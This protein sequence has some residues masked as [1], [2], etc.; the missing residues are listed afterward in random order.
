MLQ[1]LIIFESTNST[2]IEQQ[3]HQ[4][5]KHRAPFKIT[6]NVDPSTSLSPDSLQVYRRVLTTS[7]YLSEIE[8]V[9][10]HESV[11]Q[12]CLGSL[13][14]RGHTG[15][16]KPFPRLT[17]SG[18]DTECLVSSGTFD[19]FMNQT[20]LQCEWLLAA[21]SGIK[22]EQLKLVAHY[23]PEWLYESIKTF[24]RFE[25]LTDAL[26]INESDVAI[27][28]HAYAGCAG[29][30]FNIRCD[31]QN[32]SDKNESNN[33]QSL[34][35]SRVS[36]DSRVH[37]YGLIQ[38]VT[39]NRHLFRK[40]R[41]QN[42]VSPIRP[43]HVN[44]QGSKNNQ[45]NGTGSNSFHADN[46]LSN[47]GFCYFSRFNTPQPQ[48]DTAVVGANHHKADKNAY[49]DGG[50]S[51]DKQSC[52]TPAGSELVFNKNMELMS[53]IN[54]VF[55]ANKHE[56]KSEEQNNTEHDVGYGRSGLSK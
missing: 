43:D 21:L 20:K 18:F 10:R 29:S 35:S 9:L 14:N 8:I 54:H 45:S 7:P 41:I 49:S 53:V 6:F 22:L 31:S 25:G 33:T 19:G 36:P 37:S 3:T 56:R 51:L 26:I 24:S 5:N 44:N 47:S 48:K 46:R 30:T 40:T 12:L 4:L 17:L 23:E 13:Q 38:H 27:A 16:G 39:A 15:N 11:W 55:A 1:N 32:R 50:V 34:S 28:M 42:P 2:D 52:S